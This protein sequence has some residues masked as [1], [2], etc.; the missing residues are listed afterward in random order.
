MTLSQDDTLKIAKLAR[1]KL[2]SEELVRF[3]EQISKTLEYIAQLNEVKTDSVEP[4]YHPFPS[5]EIR[6]VRDDVARPGACLENGKLLILE[7]A[8]QTIYSGFQVPPILTT[9]E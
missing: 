4:L 8:P 2:T 9:E 3:T 7:H 5:N 1:L 6:T